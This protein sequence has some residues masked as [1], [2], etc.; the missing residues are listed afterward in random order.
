MLE[1]PLGSKGVAEDHSL[2]LNG[3]AASCRRS[4]IL[5]CWI[6]ITLAHSVH[7]RAVNHERFAAGLQGRSGHSMLPAM[8]VQEEACSPY[9]AFEESRN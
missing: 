9:L 7:N 4:K 1:C 3:R 5:E 6:C 2:L 8:Q